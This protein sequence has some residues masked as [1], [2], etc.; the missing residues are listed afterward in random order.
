MPSL[1]VSRFTGGH[2]EMTPLS[3]SR[4]TAGHKEMTSLS[5][6]RFTYGDAIMKY[7]LCRF[8]HPDV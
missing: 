5:M 4:F 8:M 6:S 1:G 2:K 3:M 7:S